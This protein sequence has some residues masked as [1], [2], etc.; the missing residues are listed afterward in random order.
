MEEQIEEKDGRRK[1]VKRKI[2]P[3]YVMVKMVT[4]D[5]SG[6]LSAIPGA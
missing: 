2:Y 4:T 6:M 5:E 3:G 1:A